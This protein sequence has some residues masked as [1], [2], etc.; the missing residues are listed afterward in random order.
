MKKLNSIDDML[1]QDII[2]DVASMSVDEFQTA[3]EDNKIECN[4]IDELVYELA[5][6]LQ[7]K[8]MENK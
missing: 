7:Q 2:G 8:K 6:C 5:Q 4:V 3:C 1:L